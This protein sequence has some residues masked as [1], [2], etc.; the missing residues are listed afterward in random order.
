MAKY[1]PVH[2]KIWKDPD[3]EEYSKDQKL[4]FLYLITNEQTT[5]SGIYP[6][7]PKTVSNETGIPLATVKELLANGFKNIS[8]DP[9]NRCV[10]VHKFLKYNG[11]GRP[12]LLLKSILTH[13]YHQV[14]YIPPDSELLP[15]YGRSF[16]ISFRHQSD[17]VRL[18]SVYF[19]NNHSPKYKIK[20]KAIINI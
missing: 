19:V 13:W 17:I 14:P 4:V 11:G 20:E 15:R 1:R 10:F 2:T 12:D 9:E 16:L 5:E 7:T 18:L 3:F 6:V 8:Y